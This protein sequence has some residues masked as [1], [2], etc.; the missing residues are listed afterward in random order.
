M[1]RSSFFDK[2]A[3]GEKEGSRDSKGIPFFFCYVEG[4]ETG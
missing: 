2:Y 4:E 3:T 1:T